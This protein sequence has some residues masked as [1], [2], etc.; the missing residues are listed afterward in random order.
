[1]FYLL[2]SLRYGQKLS[3]AFSKLIV[4]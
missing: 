2:L 4:M 3:L 1:M